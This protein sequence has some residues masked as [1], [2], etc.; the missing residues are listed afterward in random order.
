MCGLRAH[1]PRTSQ[2]YCAM[3]SWSSRAPSDVDAVVM[4]TPC[5]RF[6]TELPWCGAVASIKLG[7]LSSRWLFFLS[8]FVMQGPI[9][10]HDCLRTF[11][12]HARLITQV[13]HS[14]IT[15]CIH[16]IATANSQSRVPGLD[17]VA[18]ICVQQ[19]APK[20]AIL[21]QVAGAYKTF[22]S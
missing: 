22:T 16:S 8:G 4:R 17:I 20:F 7:L 6:A 10:G 18:C 19:Y 15:A 11:I 21:S 3:S 5:G 2:R 13:R 12:C 1:S 9:F 14:D